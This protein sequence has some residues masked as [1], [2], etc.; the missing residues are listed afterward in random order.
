MLNGTRGEYP[1]PMQ[2]SSQPHPRHYETLPAPPFRFGGAVGGGVPFLLVV[3]DCDDDAL[4]LQRSF[5][6]GGL[7]APFVRVCDGVEALELVW[8]RVRNGGDLPALVLLDT[9]LPRC[10]GFEV[11]RRLR[12]DAATA[13]VPVVVMTSCPL[14]EAPFVAGNFEHVAFLCKPLRAEEVRSTARALGVEL[15]ADEASKAG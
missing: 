8:E 11:L 1:Q 7:R 2:H 14:E 13:S 4:L 12:A 10:D 9:R 15:T 5:E 6:R 3:E